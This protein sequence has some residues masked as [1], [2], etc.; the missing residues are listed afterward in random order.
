MER[1]DVKPGIYLIND[2]LSQDECDN[3]VRTSENLGYE[4]AK[5]NLDGEQQLFT[6]VRNNERVLHKN[7]DWA[8]VYWN[9]LESF[10]ED[11]GNSK[12]IGLNEMFR[13]YKYT[14]QQRFKK[15][16]DG[17]YIRTQTEYS[18]L[19][20]MVYL[21]DDY[22]GGRTL[23]EDCH[24]VPERGTALIFR[25]ELKHEGEKI[26]AGTKYVFR[27]DIMFRLNST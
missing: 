22:K 3:L 26:L 1:I 24:I 10:V 11:I 12:A 16:R 7:E 18:L 23:F 27:S 19:T 21:N 4:A 17:S 13:F 8:D 14:N 9:R 6:M 25:H 2:F 15:H 20:F 5:V